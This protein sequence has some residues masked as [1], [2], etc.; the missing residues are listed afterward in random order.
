MQRNL[1]NTDILILCKKEFGG[2][3]LYKMRAVRGLV[4]MI[5][6]IFDKMTARNRSGVVDKCYA[7]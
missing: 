6:N 7:L 3:F 2:F 5:K 4:C 1:N